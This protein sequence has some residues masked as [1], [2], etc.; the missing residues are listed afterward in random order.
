V[1][2]KTIVGNPP[3]SCK[4]NVHLKVLGKLQELAEKNAIISLVMPKQVLAR[5]L[6]R[7]K[8]YTSWIDEHTSIEHHDVNLMKWFPTVKSVL[9]WFSFK[10][11]LGRSM[12]DLTVYPEKTWRAKHI[13]GVGFGCNVYSK[14]ESEVFCVPVM[15]IVGKD[16]KSVMRNRFTIQSVKEKYEQT[17]K[18]KP[19]LH[20]CCLNAATGCRR[21]FLDETGTIIPFSNY[22]MSFK[23]EDVNEAREC[24]DWINSVDGQ[25]FAESWLTLSTCASPGLTLLFEEQS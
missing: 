6:K 18:G 2:F 4:T 7:N 25:R 15:I 16:G 22:N 24:R 1:K 13:R 10:T 9:F 20:I 12:V 14:V 8:K 17:T 21:A 19:V 11:D 5:G 3:F 23:F